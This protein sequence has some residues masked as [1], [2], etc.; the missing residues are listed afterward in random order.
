[1]RTSRKRDFC[2]IDIAKNNFCGI[3]ISQG[4]DLEPPSLYRYFPLVK[5]TVSMRRRSILLFN[6]PYMTSVLVMRS[7]YACNW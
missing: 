2:S 1:M 4:L 7:C 5:F 3:D 6:A